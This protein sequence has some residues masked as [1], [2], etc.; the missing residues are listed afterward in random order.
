MGKPSVLSWQELRG[1][2]WQHS[3]DVVCFVNGSLLGDEKQLCSWAEKQ[4]MFTFYRPQALYTALAQEC[5]TKHL[6]STGVSTALSSWPS[7]CPSA[8]HIHTCVYTTLRSLVKSPLRR[9]IILTVK[10]EQ[11]NINVHVFGM[12]NSGSHILAAYI[13]LTWPMGTLRFI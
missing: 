4:W 9:V 8:P 2:M 12:S 1:E 13:L 7:L 10:G 3:G 5:Y 6:H 11:L